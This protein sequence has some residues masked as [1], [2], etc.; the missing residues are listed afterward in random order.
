MAHKMPRTFYVI[1]TNISREPQLVWERGSSWGQNILSFELN[2]PGMRTTIISEKRQL[3][4]KNTPRSFLVSPGEHKVYAVTLDENWKARPSLPTRDELPITLKVKYDVPA[5]SE[6]IRLNV[7]AGH[8]ESREY[9][10]T[11]RQW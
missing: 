7:W 8:V 6:A 1:V 3:F 11:L 9:E 10:L 4:T 5:S 2:A